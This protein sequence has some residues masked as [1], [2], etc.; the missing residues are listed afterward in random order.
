MN[1]NACKNMLESITYAENHVRNTLLCNVL[2]V[3][4]FSCKEEMENTVDIWIFNLTAS[5]N[6]IF[7]KVCNLSRKECE[8]GCC[9]CN[10]LI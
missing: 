1:K 3:D 4:D 5:L 6:K 7:F 2:S 8:G 9:T 10:F